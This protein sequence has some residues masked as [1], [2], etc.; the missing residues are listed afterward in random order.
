MADNAKLAAQT[1]GIPDDILF[2]WMKIGV[3]APSKHG[4]RGRWGG[5]E[6]T[7]RD[8]ELLRLAVLLRKLKFPLASIKFTLDC[9]NVWQWDSQ[10]ITLMVLALGLKK[11]SK[12][13]HGSFTWD[14]AWKHNLDAA[15]SEL[16]DVRVLSKESWTYLVCK[17]I[18]NG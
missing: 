8:V 9:L 10:P 6:F 12:S 7:A 18:K 2:Y 3:I 1:A 11:G 4:K 17:V 14:G 5:H 15:M 13:N 16:R